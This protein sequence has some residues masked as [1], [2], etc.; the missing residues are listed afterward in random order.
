MV[1]PVLFV[2][3]IALVA[4][5]LIGR[6]G[7]RGRQVPLKD[8]EAILLRMALGDRALVERLI[9]AEARRH[10]DGIR[11]Q[12]AREAVLRWEASLR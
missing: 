4:T 3:V 6:G 2:V 10:P 11:Q 1:T 8:S 7:S 9:A 5:V 12:W